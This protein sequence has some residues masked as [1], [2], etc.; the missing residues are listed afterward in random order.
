MADHPKRR[1]SDIPAVQHII[2][3]VWPSFLTAGLATIIFFT[4]FNPEEISICL[5][6]TK[7]VNNVG[8]Y[9][10]GF[11]LFWTLTSSACALTCYFQ[12]PCHQSASHRD[13][14]NISQ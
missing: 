8:A 11:F 14:N 13:T 1:K 6:N 4:A 10:I 7:P 2:A 5:G 3:V 12:R 9:T